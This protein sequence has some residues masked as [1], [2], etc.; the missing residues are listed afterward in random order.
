MYELILPISL[1]AFIFC[2]V[3]YLYSSVGLGGGTSY[4]ALLVLF[5]AGPQIIPTISLTLNILVTT[6]GAIV[7]LARGYGRISLITP[8]LISSIPMAYI[9]GLLQLPKL[10]FYVLLLVSLCLAA[11]RIYFPGKVLL[12]LKLNDR[13]RVISALICGAI[14]GLLAGI[15]G[16]GGGIYLV[17]L[18]ILLGLGTEKEAAACGAI[19]VWANSISGL[20]A[21]LQYSEVDIISYGV[22]IIAVGVGGLAGSLSG[23]L[24]FSPKTMQKMLGSVLVVA[25][26]FMGKKVVSLT[27]M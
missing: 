16:I 2:C 14:L 19:F 12:N 26:F 1:M 24:K 11:W 6:V 25:V 23:A 10:I 15:V 27:L 21:R 5:G 7:F 22:L 13:V 9:G 17:P 4:T 20:A 3:A 8:F 18:V